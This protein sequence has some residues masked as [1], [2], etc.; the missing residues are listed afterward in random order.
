MLKEIY[1]RLGIS[2]SLEEEHQRFYQRILLT[3]EELNSKLLDYGSDFDEILNEVCFNLGKENKGSFEN[4][5]E[6]ETLE[7]YLI[8]CE[9]ILSV[10]SSLYDKVIYD[11]FSSRINRA[12][13]NSILDLG[14]IFDKKNDKFIIKGAKE[15]D[16]KLI[17]EPL[18]WLENYPIV[19]KSFSGALEEYLKKD[20]PDAIT[21]AYS[22]LE[23][24]VKTFLDSDKRLDSLIPDLLK[25]LNFTK[26]WQSILVNY[27]KYAHEFSSRHGKKENKKS[28]P[29]EPIQA[30]SYIYFTG[31]IIRIIIQSIN[32]KK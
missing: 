25:T 18:D 19:K 5:L 13:E 1:N 28:S 17:L 7:E 24:L 9:V 6:N 29:A 23:S 27:S 16:E 31:L 30:E 10:L 11:F 3:F 15:L 22:S 2:S 20:Y 26:E 21:K 12:I 14:V 4:I 32:E 8:A